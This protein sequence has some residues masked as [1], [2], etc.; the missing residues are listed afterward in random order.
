MDIG[1]RSHCLFFTP[2]KSVYGGAGTLVLKAKVQPGV[3]PPRPTARAVCGSPAAWAAVPGGL[4]PFPRP[5]CAH[6]PHPE[7]RRGRRAAQAPLGRVSGRAV[8][9]SGG[10]LWPSLVPRVLFAPCVF[11]QAILGSF[12]QKHKASRREWPGSQALML[13]FLPRRARPSARVL[14]VKGRAQGTSPTHGLAPSSSLLPNW[15]G[16]TPQARKRRLSPVP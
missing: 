1:S 16:P 14:T 5:A 9:G 6:S 10:A 4:N 11:M 12:L 8:L 15:A 7:A 2:N 13:P 3:A